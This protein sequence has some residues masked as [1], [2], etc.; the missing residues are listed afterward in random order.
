MKKIFGICPYSMKL[1]AD[2]SNLKDQGEIKIER[3]RLV[4]LLLSRTPKNWN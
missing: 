3:L 1:K 4:E 2:N